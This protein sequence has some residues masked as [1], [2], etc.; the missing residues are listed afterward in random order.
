MNRISRVANANKLPEGGRGLLWKRAMDITLALPLTIVL[1]PLMAVLALAIRIESPGPALLT[2]ERVGLAGRP[3]RMY[4]FRSMHWGSTDEMH[5]LAV[6]NWFAGVAKQESYKIAKDPRVTRV[7]HILRR[8]ALDELPQL[9]N[10][11]VGTMSLVGPRPAMPYELHQYDAWY[12]KRF[13]VPPGITGP[14]QVGKH[15]QMPA[16]KMI[17]MDLDYVTRI[18]PLTDIRLLWLTIPAALR[19]AR[20][21]G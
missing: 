7:G 3:F 21:E 5:R 19:H 6:Q 16:S 14:W 8:T 4:K 10:V 12:F 9:F 1:L 11:I 17:E 2:Q 13:V 15:H 18:S 20:Y